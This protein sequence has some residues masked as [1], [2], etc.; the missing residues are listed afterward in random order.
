M[1][2][3]T[4]NQTTPPVTGTDTKAGAGTKSKTAA[5]AAAKASAKAP[6]KASAKSKKLIL[7]RSTLP[8]K[9]EGGDEVV[10]SEQD[11]RHPGGQAF[12]AGKTP[13]EVF[14]TPAVTALIKNEKLKDV[15]NGDDEEEEATDDAEETEE[16]DE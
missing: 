15:T 3:T 9:P 7:V 12:I 4:D 8:P 2:E 5:K 16:T 6:A 1:A 10:L 14:P 11:S 13:V